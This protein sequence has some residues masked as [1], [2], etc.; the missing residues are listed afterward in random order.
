MEEFLS[1]VAENWYMYLLMLIL[2]LALRTYKYLVFT[3]S[4][5]FKS[6]LRELLLELL[7][8]IIVLTALILFEFSGFT[9]HRWIYL[10]SILLSDSLLKWFIKQ[11]DKITEGLV[12]KLVNII[13]EDNNNNLNKDEKKLSN[14]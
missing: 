1:N 6:V 14:E 8:D 10:V 5:K 3:E 11:Q 9:V 7:S 13:N 2:S 12:K 4:I